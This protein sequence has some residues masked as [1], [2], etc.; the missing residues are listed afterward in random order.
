MRG[1]E[2]TGLLSLE[3]SKLFLYPVYL[4][5]SQHLSGSQSISLSPLLHH[6]HSWQLNTRSK[7]SVT[8]T[9][10]TVNP[11][12]TATQSTA[13]LKA[14]PKWAPGS[15]SMFCQKHGWGGG[16]EGGEAD[17][18]NRRKRRERKYEKGWEII[19]GLQPIAFTLF[20]PQ[21]RLEQQFLIFLIVSDPLR[22]GLSWPLGTSARGRLPQHNRVILGKKAPCVCPSRRL[23]TGAARLP[24]V[25]CV[26]SGPAIQTP[27]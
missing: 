6:S 16:V 2:A 9:Y 4:I 1:P 25:C 10:D 20:Q 24:W 22:L 8:Q 11:C 15:Q 13:A 19:E 12:S 7:S 26:C 17:K 18:K 27:S 14:E 5:D 3:N 21:K 23:E